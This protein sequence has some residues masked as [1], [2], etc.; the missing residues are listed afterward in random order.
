MTLSRRT[1]AYSL[2][3]VA[4]LAAIFSPSSLGFSA[5]IGTSPTTD[6]SPGGISGLS[7]AMRGWGHTVVIANTSE[8]LM[9]LTGGRGATLVMLDP[10]VA[11][12]TSQVQTMDSRFGAGNLSLLIAEGNTTNNVL[13]RTL[14]GAKV[15]GAAITDPSS[16][17][18]DNR[19]F[20]VTLTL[21]S[22]TVNGVVDVASRLETNGSSLATAAASSP[23][24]TDSMNGTAGP[25]TVVGAEQ[26]QAGSRALV[27]TDHSPFTNEFLAGSRPS[28]NDTQFVRT[29]VD[30]VSAAGNGTI[31][32]DGSGYAGGAGSIPFSFGIPVGAIMS[33]IFVTVIHSFVGTTGAAVSSGGLLG[34]LFAGSPLAFLAVAF[35]LLGGLWMLRFIGKRLK[36]VYATDV[37]VYDDQ[38][39]PVVERNLL[40]RSAEMTDFATMARKKSF[41]VATCAQLYDVVDDASRLALGEGI[42]TLTPQKIASASGRGDASKEMAFLAEL[43][44]V[45]TYATGKKRLYLPPVFS[46]KRKFSS[47]ASQAETYLNEIGLSMKGEGAKSVEYALKK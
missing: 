24:S 14:F 4:F 23:L 34:S 21:G 32:L 2:L 22:S 42:Q 20:T 18:T 17:F 27:I 45:H 36:G 19:I 40:A 1:L 29:M 13:L 10:N 41:Y 8:Q 7:G 46:W 30:W 15:T 33:L 47:L 11:L 12:N 6:S 5:Q 25:R 26:D 38:P 43:S 31:V 37:A 9:S 28:T 35:N 44:K 39:L 16:P 3:A